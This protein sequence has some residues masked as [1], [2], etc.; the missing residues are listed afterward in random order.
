[1][2]K[3]TRRFLCDVKKEN[4]ADSVNAYMAKSK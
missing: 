1:M 4:G 3:K 2:S